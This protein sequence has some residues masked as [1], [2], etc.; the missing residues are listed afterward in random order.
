MLDDFSVVKI[1]AKEPEATTAPQQPQG[2]A[3]PRA[4]SEAADADE[5]RVLSEEELF[6]KQLQAGMAG[7]LGELTNHVSGRASPN[8]EQSH[9]TI[10]AAGDADRV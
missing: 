10:P 1:E 3:T 6:T 8:G 9:L 4:A 7:L 2:H 5:E